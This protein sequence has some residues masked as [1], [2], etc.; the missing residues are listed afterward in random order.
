MNQ[1]ISISES[2]L[3]RTSLILNEWPLCDQLYFQNLLGKLW[4][5]YQK[6]YI[7]PLGIN[8]L[9]LISPGKLWRELFLWVIPHLDG[10]L[11]IFSVQLFIPNYYIL[12][13]LEI[14]FLNVKEKEMMRHQLNTIQVEI[15]RPGSIGKGLKIVFRNL[16]LFRSMESWKTVIQMSRQKEMWNKYG[17]SSYIGYAESEVPKGYSPFMETQFCHGKG[18]CIT[19]WN[20]EPCYAGQP[21]MD[22]T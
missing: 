16:W 21:K 6:T 15:K 17:R 18:T 19:Q 12:Q 22:G 11:K 13:I 2:K 5:I 9:S 20:Y 7:S 4:P 10:W 14:F 1:A 3:Y 8:F